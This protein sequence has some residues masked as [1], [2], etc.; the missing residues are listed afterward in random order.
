MIFDVRHTFLG[1]WDNFFS[2]LFQINNLKS[3]IASSRQSALVSGAPLYPPPPYFFTPSSEG[4]GV[5]HLRL[6]NG[7]SGNLLISEF[8]F[9]CLF[10]AT[11][12][13][14]ESGKGRIKQT[15]RGRNQTR[16]RG[17]LRNSLLLTQIWYWLQVL[18]QL[19]AFSINCF[20]T[21][22]IDSTLLT[23]I[24][25]I[26]HHE[27]EMQVGKKTSQITPRDSY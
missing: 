17:K 1:K 22:F 15:S 3:Q 20:L 13:R 2:V 25:C 11:R 23:Y 7:K 8:H 18:I 5:G 16:A 26:S 14:T 24:I 9:Y 27:W 4:S 12:R 21:G 6:F 19:S 10:S